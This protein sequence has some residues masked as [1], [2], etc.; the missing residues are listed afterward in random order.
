MATLADRLGSP[1]S[2]LSTVLSGQRHLSKPY[3]DGIHAL[4]LRSLQ[5][6]ETDD[7]TAS[8]G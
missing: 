1:K 3:V 5:A 8:S 4:V 6:K 2:I 7:D